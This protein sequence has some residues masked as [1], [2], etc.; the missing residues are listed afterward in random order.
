MKRT[1]IV[2]QTIGKYRDSFIEYI[3][4]T[5]NQ[6]IKNNEEKIML[7]YDY[8]ADVLKLT[9]DNFN[10][11]L[12]AKVNALT[13][14]LVDELNLGAKS[15]IAGILYISHEHNSLEFDDI[16]Q[17]YGG[18]IAEIV[19]A[20][21]RI[22]VYS[23]A[24]PKNKSEHIR[25]LL[26]TISFDVRVTFIILAMRLQEIRNESQKEV[27]ESTKKFAL[28]TLDV[29]API[30]HRIG[31]YDFKT[32]LEDLSFKISQPDIYKYIAEQLDGSEKKRMLSI[33]TFSIPIIEALDKMGISFNIDG[34]VKSIYSIWNK[35]QK[36]HVAIFDIYDIY[37][38]RIIFDT[39]DNLPE[40]TQCWNIFSVITQIYSPKMDRIRNWVNKPKDNGYEALHVTV[41]SSDDKWVEVQIRSKRMD[42]LASLGIAAH[43]K[44]KGESMDETAFDKL[45]QQLNA[46]KELNS[47][48]SSD[49][50]DNFKPKIVHRDIYVFTP[51]NEIV[52]LKKNSTVL[53]FAFYIHTDIG[54]S[55]LGAKVNYKSVAPEF[56][57]SSGDRVEILTSSK[58]RLKKEWVDIVETKKAKQNI[59]S[60]FRQERKIIVRKGLI[61]IEKL[62]SQLNIYFDNYIFRKLSRQFQTQ[63]KEQ[64]YFKIGNNEISTKE[65]V[66]TLKERSKE[67]RINFWKIVLNQKIEDSNFTIKLAT[68]CVPS[69]G[70]E[71]IG[72]YNEHL[73]VAHKNDCSMAKTLL[74]IHS[75][76]KVRIKWQ[77]TKDEANLVTLNFRGNDRT[78]I[79]NRVSAIVANE[80]NINMRSIHFE[81][82]QRNFNGRI[83]LY[84]PPNYLLNDFIYRLNQIKGMKKIERL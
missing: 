26:L 72:L 18:R 7:A 28:E 43:W 39:A 29:Y 58:Q 56:V 38:I 44:Y 30:A 67:K 51:K 37:A 76:K 57:L 45:F 12:I 31:L 68:C 77:A 69:P 65:I 75:S 53:D 33:N 52:K 74:G 71:L 15:V 73:I 79:V 84:I 36:K 10:N 21:T 80:I 70:S 47:E 32:E 16:K 14:I 66:D 61:Q 17:W 60:A 49:F 59:K 55:C 78:G 5:A 27:T 9:R 3:T 40:S 83:E 35:I 81:S 19:V 23:N 63:T 1:N 4:Q 25:N 8:V 2:D 6:S 64:L 42:E 41:K 24:N 46:L 22:P 48:S 62:T 13:E 82:D 50:L 34:R 11:L 54:L 20:L